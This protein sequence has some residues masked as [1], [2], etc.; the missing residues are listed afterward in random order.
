MADALTDLLRAGAR[1]LLAQAVEAEVTDFLARHRE[2]MADGRS[3]VVR[4]GY[5]P[6]RTIQTGIGSVEVTAPR[7]RDRKGEITFTSALLPPYLRR[8]RSIEAVLP[9]LYLTGLAT[10]DFGEALVALLGKDAPALSAAT[11]SR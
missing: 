6:E 7:V 2:V 10:G 11:I 9:W 5:L 3:R 8:T 4:N 1:Q